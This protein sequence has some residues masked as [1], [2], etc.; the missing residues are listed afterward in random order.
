LIKAAA[1]HL[2]HKIK[3]LLINMEQKENFEPRST[4][5]PVNK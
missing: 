1:E 5:H 4:S 3:K 2:F